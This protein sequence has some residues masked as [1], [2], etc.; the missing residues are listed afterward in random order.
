MI[1]RLGSI[2][3]LLSLGAASALA[4]STHGALVGT[5][6]DKSGGVVPNAT[7]VATELETNVGKIGATNT[8]GDYEIPNLLPGTYDISGG[9]GFPSP[10]T[11]RRRTSTRS[12][13]S[14]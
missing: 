12:T 14:P 5:I 13:A 1:R 8:F 9:E 4:Q 6:R 10:A 7:V 3:A 11:I 2:L